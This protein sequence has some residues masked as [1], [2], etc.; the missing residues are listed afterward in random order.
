MT[1]RRSFRRIG[2]FA[3]LAFV[4]CGCEAQDTDRLAR[5]ARRIAA[6]FDT[7]TSSADDKITAGWQAFRSDLN[8]MSLDT[9]VSARLR[10]DKGLAGA[11]I[12]VQ[13]KNGVVE[14]KGPVADLT[15]RRRAV[16]IAESTIGAEKVTDLLEVP[17]REP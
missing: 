14:L 4:A 8:E 7:V 17:T 6:K 16:E 1:H 13:A 5:A 12:Q 15:Q 2:L 3:F 11:K 10:W 9:R